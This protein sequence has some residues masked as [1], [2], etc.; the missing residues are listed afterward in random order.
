MRPIFSS[1][2]AC[3]S[4]DSSSSSIPSSTVF[5]RSRLSGSAQCWISA[6]CS[7]SKVF[8]FV[9]TMGISGGS[10]E[11][12]WGKSSAYKTPNLHRDVIELDQRD[13]VFLSS[14]DKW[15]NSLEIPYTIGYFF[16]DSRNPSNQKIRSSE[17]TF[18][19]I[20]T[21]CW[22][23]R[24]YENTS[25]CP[26]YVLNDIGCWTHNDQFLWLNAAS[27]RNL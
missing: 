5:W 13:Q 1:F 17:Y 20:K 26:W 9:Y 23:G 2:K 22:S 10:S 19:S 4:S 14:I 15:E 16:F 27:V 25:A 8:S 11:S 6:Y 3:P 7:S 18:P 24:N 12:P 21:Q